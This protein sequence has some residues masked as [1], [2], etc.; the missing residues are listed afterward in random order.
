MI[1]VHR[2]GGAYDHYGIYE[3][4]DCIYEYAAR[5]HDFGEANI[6]KTTLQKFIKDSG[7]FFILVF[8]DKHGSPGKLAMP[9]AG[10]A[11]NV[12][13]NPSLDIP[14]GLL[15]L[16][17]DS[18]EYHLYSPDE[19]IRRA[20]SRLGETQYNLITNNCEHFAIWCKT[21]MHESHQV[22]AFLRRLKKLS[23]VETV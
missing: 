6:H 21:G 20:K 18:A 3:S 13:R 16:L 10:G 17:N 1:G 8:P 14:L 15:N 4:D 12:I 11:A 23:G 9:V 5:N 22:D 19:T 7:N 2:I